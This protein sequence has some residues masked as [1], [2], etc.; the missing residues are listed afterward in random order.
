MTMYK[1]RNLNPISPV[2]RDILAGD[3][4]LVGA[5]VEKPDAIIVRSADMH[6]MDIED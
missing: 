3:K 2:Y 6:E 5:E 4:Y 1:I